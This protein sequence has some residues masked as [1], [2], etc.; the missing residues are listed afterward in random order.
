MLALY[1][2]LDF[3]NH[4]L[5]QSTEYFVVTTDQNGNVKSPINHTSEIIV[6][7]NEGRGK[8]MYTKYLI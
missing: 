4:S 7:R 2:F 8:E 3:Q 6:E 1:W 5:R